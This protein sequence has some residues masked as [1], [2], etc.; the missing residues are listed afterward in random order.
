MRKSLLKAIGKVRRKFCIELTIHSCIVSRNFTESDGLHIEWSR[1]SQS[2]FTNAVPIKNKTATWNETLTLYSTLSV[3][4]KTGKCDKKPTRLVLKQFSIRGNR[5]FG[6]VDLDLSKYASNNRLNLSW[7]LRFSVRKCGDPNA[8]LTASIL[9]KECNDVS[10]ADDSSSVTT[11]ESETTADAVISEVPIRSQTCIIRNKDMSPLKSA[12]GVFQSPDLSSS[13]S[14]SEAGSA[15]QS[16]GIRRNSVPILDS[17]FLEEYAGRRSTV[18]ESV[19]ASGAVDIRDEVRG[20][21]TDGRHP[22]HNGSISLQDSLKYESNTDLK[23]EIKRLRTDLS[24]MKGKCMKQILDNDKVLQEAKDKFQADKESLISTFDAEKMRNVEV[25]EKGRFYLLQ[26]KAL[27]EENSALRSALSDAFDRSAEQNHDLSKRL[28]TA[29]KEAPQVFSGNHHQKVVRGANMEPKKNS[30]KKLNVAQFDFL[31]ALKGEKSIGGRASP[32]AKKSPA[33]SSPKNKVRGLGNALSK[34]LQDTFEDSSPKSKASKDRL[35]SPELEHLALTRPAGPRRK[36][37]GRPGLL[38]AAT[39][40]DSDLTLSQNDAPIREKHDLSHSVSSNPTGN[41]PRT[42]FDNDSK[43]QSRERVSNHTDTKKPKTR[44]DSDSDSQSLPGSSNQF[45]AEKPKSVIYSDPKSRIVELEQHVKFLKEKASD[46][47]SKRKERV[48]AIKSMSKSEIDKSRLGQEKAHARMKNVEKEMKSIKKEY[49]H[50]IGKLTDEIEA[51]KIAAVT[52]ATTDDET[53]QRIKDLES[54]LSSVKKDLSTSRERQSKISEKNKLLEEK[55]SKIQGIFMISESL[56]ADSAKL[57]EKTEKLKL[58]LSFRRIQVAKSIHEKFGLYEKRIHELE[59]EVSNTKDE[60]RV[61]S[62]EKT[63]LSLAFTQLQTTLAESRSQNET[64]VSSKQEQ[65]E[66]SKKHIE[67]LRNE[68]ACSREETSTSLA[69]S[70][71]LTRQLTSL[72]NNLVETRSQFEKE[73]EL[74]VENERDN[75]KSQISDLKQRNH[76]QKLKIEEERTKSQGLTSE[77]SQLLSQI[78]RLTNDLDEEE[79]SAAKVGARKSADSQS[80]ID[81]LTEEL[82]KKKKLEE[83]FSLM[84]IVLQNER[85]RRQAIKKERDAL[86]C[87]RKRAEK[88]EME[89]EELRKEEIRHRSSIS[90]DKG[91]LEEEIRFLDEDNKSLREELKSTADQIALLRQQDIAMGDET[92]AEILK[93]QIERDDLRRLM[94]VKISDLETERDSLKTAMDSK[95]SELLSERDSLKESTESTKKEKERVE[96]EILRRDEKIKDLKRNVKKNVAQITLLRTKSVESDDKVKSEIS[97][98]QRER[99]HLKSSTDSLELE[100]S[101]LAQEMERRVNATEADNQSSSKR[102]ESLERDFAKL[103]TRYSS[104]KTRIT[105]LT[106]ELSNTQ[107]CLVEETKTRLRLFQ[108]C[109]D[110]RERQESLA[111]KKNILQS[112]NTELKVVLE[113]SPDELQ[114]LQRA[115]LFHQK[116]ESDAENDMTMLREAY[117]TTTTVLED[118]IGCLND[119]IVGLKARVIFEK[120]RSRDRRKSAKQSTKEPDTDKSPID[121]TVKLSDVSEALSRSRGDLRKIFDCDGCMNCEKHLHIGFPFLRNKK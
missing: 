17:V 64:L 85:E 47:R 74:A 103:R 111:R 8:K 46:E 82:E 36:R 56:S 116:Q 92:N 18:A 12:L 63:D 32:G 119:E 69:E 100:K 5:Q 89:L 81:H 2:A 112:K 60:N 43:S 35:S 104:A 7:D 73:L 54:S 27:Q 117:G 1:G 28:G 90:G 13:R 26:V 95:I 52:V 86:E 19:D 105:K 76:H 62:E 65:F 31:S 110:L 107:T 83:E 38:R 40:A 71:D 4:A 44:I 93:L 91:D 39:F 66:Q 51:F 10:N 3:D 101:K 33:T 23:H 78:E 9:V 45:E 11:D 94:N 118:Q 80:E 99:D 25:V 29:Q 79:F 6:C 30:P 24:S 42:R 106:E 37:A 87:E 21:I 77:K 34:F 72:T 75:S 61:A 67:L 15:S 115:V 98:L 70:T 53:N 57:T 113:S 102:M 108:T 68:L 109:Q 97:E 22:R 120:E 96:G 84:K 14:Q 121:I 20:C 59:T 41:K 58:S 50:T 16:A 49:E 88:L 48:S 55:Q 114:D